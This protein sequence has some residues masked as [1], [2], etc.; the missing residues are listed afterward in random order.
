MHGFPC[1]WS[2][3]VL[4]RLLVILPSNFIATLSPS[5]GRGDGEAVVEGLRVNGKDIAMT[6]STTI[7]DPA[8]ISGCTVLSAVLILPVGYDADS[9]SSP[10]LSSNSKILYVLNHFSFNFPLL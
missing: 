10:L 1:P 8:P 6:E 4:F 3:L 2:W 5:T 7:W 9:L